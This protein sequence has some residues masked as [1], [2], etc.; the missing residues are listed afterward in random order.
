[1]IYES[2]TSNFLA[3]LIMELLCLRW[4][5]NLRSYDGVWTVT[6]HSYANTEVPTMGA[7]QM[8]KITLREINTIYILIYLGGGKQY[9]MIYHLLSTSITWPGIMANTFQFLDY[10]MHYATRNSFFQPKEGVIRR[11]RGLMDY[12]SIPAAGRNVWRVVG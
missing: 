9:L 1:M 3:S 10:F 5:T 7:W 2:M 11:P 8:A 4:T 12:G 6:V